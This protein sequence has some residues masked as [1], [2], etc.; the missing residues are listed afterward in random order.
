MKTSQQEE[1]ERI[2]NHHFGVPVVKFWFNSMSAL[3][4]YSVASCAPSKCN[5]RPNLEDPRQFGGAGVSSE[6]ELLLL[7]VEQLLLGN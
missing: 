4:S 7:G 5:S 1:V 3:D 6:E 2:G